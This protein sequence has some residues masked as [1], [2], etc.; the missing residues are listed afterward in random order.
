[1]L[2]LM[3]NDTAVKQDLA[4]KLCL[5]L[6][7]NLTHDFYVGGELHTHS[8]LRRGGGGR[9]AHFQHHDSGYTESPVKL[10]KLTKGVSISLPSSPLLPRQP[11]TLSSPLC[12]KFPGG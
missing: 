1:M 6:S 12:M 4:F 7:S 8:T 2:N 3:F 9:A 11:N 10:T 5:G